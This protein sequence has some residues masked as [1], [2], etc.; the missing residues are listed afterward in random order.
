MKKIK[1]LIYI[2][3]FIFFI[4]IKA[5]LVKADNPNVSLPDK[6]CA[7]YHDSGSCRDNNCAWNNDYNF[8]SPN[9]LVYL[10]CGDAYD[11]PEMVPKLTSIA[12]TLLK[13]V[14]PV[15]LIVMSIISLIKSITS[16]KEDEIKKAQGSLIKRIIAAAIVFFIVS[17]VQF[18]MMKVA[19]DDNE[20]KQLSSC[21][22]CFLNGT[23]K[24]GNLYYKDGYGYCY[25]ADTGKLELCN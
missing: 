16:G 23:N 2:I 11:I 5:D 21:L 1:Y 7:K 15:I 18:V 9:G 6:S 13:T 14:T 17:I 3:L 10:K 22:S 12:V 20:R 4:S 25:N 8:C 24:C 19:E